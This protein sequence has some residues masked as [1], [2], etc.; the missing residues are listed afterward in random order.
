MRDKYDN[1]MWYFTCVFRSLIKMQKRN[2]NKMKKKLIVYLSTGGIM[3]KCFHGSAI[4]LLW[5]ESHWAAKVARCW[6]GCRL[7]MFV[8]R[9]VT[10][11]Y[12]LVAGFVKPVCVRKGNLPGGRFARLHRPVF[13]CAD[14]NT[15]F[16]KSQIFEAQTRQSL[17]FLRAQQKRTCNYNVSA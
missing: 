13:V 16:Q 2:L 11:L 8:V 3:E 1:I 7:S 9:I 10:W 5:F 14:T 4:V 12:T 15:W 17:F 6:A